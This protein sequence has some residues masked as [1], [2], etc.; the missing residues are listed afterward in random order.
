MFSKKMKGN[1]IFDV[2]FNSP[3]SDLI[4]TDFY[5]SIPQADVVESDKGFSYY[6]ALPGFEKEDI[7]VELENNYLKISAKKKEDNSAHYKRKEFDY[8]GS[9]RKLLVH[10]AADYTTMKAKYTDGIL[11]IEVDKKAD[12]TN[13]IHISI[14]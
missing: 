3:F 10:D 6:V 2:F 4:S 7:S 13:N 11:K 1:N 8:G 9:T 12:V 14:N 5:H